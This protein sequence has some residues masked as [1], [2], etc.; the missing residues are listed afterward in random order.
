MRKA[1]LLQFQMD[2]NIHI[3]GGIILRSWNH[4]IHSLHTSLQIH[5]R[6]SR[7]IFSDNKLRVNILQPEKP[8]LAIHQRL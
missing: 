5:R 8:T 2:R 3:H 7:L 1:L 4:H 6:L